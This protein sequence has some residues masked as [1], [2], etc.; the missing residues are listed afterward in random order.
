M[1]DFMYKYILISF[2]ML[3]SSCSS[4]EKH[5]VNDVVIEKDIVLARMNDASER[6]DWLDESTPMYV[7]DGYI[8]ALGNTTLDGEARVEAGYRIAENNAKAVLSSSIEQKLDFVFQNAEEGTDL[9]STQ[10]KFIGGEF[11]NLTANSLLPNKRYWEKV[12]MSKSSGQKT[13]IYKIFATV[14]MKE[15]DFKTAVLE[16]IKCQ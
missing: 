14:K 3:L 9:T 4:T 16:S 6:P 7:K 13:I 8:Y 12:A 5:I 10:A 11:S 1:G 15:S 2:G